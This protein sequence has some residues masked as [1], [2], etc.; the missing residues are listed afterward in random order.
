MSARRGAG[1]RGWRRHTGPGAPRSQPGLRVCRTRRRGYS[2]G[3][4]AL[5]AAARILVR[6][7]EKGSRMGDVGETQARLTAAR[8]AATRQRA[9]PGVRGPIGCEPTPAGSDR[10]TISALASR[11]RGTKRGSTGNRRALRARGHRAGCA[12][13][14]RGYAEVQERPEPRREAG[15]VG[16][17]GGR[18]PR[19]GSNTRRR[20]PPEWRAQR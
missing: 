11:C 5:P 10:L 7:W 4:T 2:L 18:Q 1:P 9:S 6:A 13:R 15:E 16:S 17:R 19:T 20:L 8:T 3:T 12:A 14:R